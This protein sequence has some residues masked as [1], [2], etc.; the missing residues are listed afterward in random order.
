MGQQTC[1]FVCSQ[2]QL[3]TSPSIS[4]TTWKHTQVRRVEGNFRTL[5]QLELHCSSNLGLLWEL[6]LFVGATIL[7][8][9]EVYIWNRYE[10]D[11]SQATLPAFVRRCYSKNYSGIFLFSVGFLNQKDTLVKKWVFWSDGCCFCLLLY[12][13][14]VMVLPCCGC[15]RVPGNPGDF[16]SEMQKVDQWRFVVQIVQ[17]QLFCSATK[18]IN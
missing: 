7:V 8:S 3:S 13:G 5:A 1:P 9:S 11:I 18:Y 4:L 6:G 15:R 16:N 2:L 17:I 14:C 10:Q 12:T